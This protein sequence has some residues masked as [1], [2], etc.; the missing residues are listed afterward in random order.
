[1]EWGTGYIAHFRKWTSISTCAIF[2]YSVLPQTG[3]FSAAVT[4]FCAESLKSLSE[5]PAVTTN[6]LLSVLSKQLADSNALPAGQ[7]P[8]EVFVPTVQNVR[9]NVLYFLSLTLALSVSSICILGKQWIREYQKDISVSPCDAVRL[10]QARLDALVAY[11]VPQILASLPVI[12]LMALLLFFSG[13]LTQLWNV[14]D[15]TTATLVSIVVAL[16]AFLAITTTIIP[17]HHSGHAL[18]GINL[19]PF[20]SPQAWAY[21]AAYQRICKTSLAIR[22]A[23]SRLLKGMSSDNSD[24]SVSSPNPIDSWAEL[25]MSCLKEENLSVSSVITSV[26][27]ALH[28]TLKT[29]GNASEIESSVLWCLQRQ[30][31]P[32]HIKISETQLGRYVL[33][34]DTASDDFE[35]SEEL[36]CLD[37]L[38]YSHIMTGSGSLSS[39]EGP[40]G[41]QPAELII[42]FANHAINSLIPYQSEANDVHGAYRVVVEC[43]RKLGMILSSLPPSET[44]TSL[45]VVQKRT[46]G[47]TT[48]SSR[49]SELNYYPSRTRHTSRANEPYASAVFLGFENGQSYSK[50]RLEAHY[51]CVGE[52][53]HSCQVV[54]SYMAYH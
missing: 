12:L 21:M 48:C 9:I 8:S 13:L 1:M 25:D 4:A 14:S 36:D 11:Q 29:L 35:V 31:H 5:D 37:H 40:Y 46:S 33:P 43:W 15:H 17:A 53:A 22:N 41:N 34:G 52:I 49:P 23:C 16:T 38:Y 24:M 18:G 6:S 20:R 30:H 32:P 2:S 51:Q 54:G 3:L 28:W 26:H 42:R 19:T 39:T 45:K 7:S 27:R 44:L 50:A 10:R 47:C